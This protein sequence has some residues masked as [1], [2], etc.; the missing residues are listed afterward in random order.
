MNRSCNQ[1]HFTSKHLDS[2]NSKLGEV[3]GRRVN[4]S[5]NDAIAFNEMM[6]ESKGRWSYL[7]YC[8]FQEMNK[9]NINLSEVE[10]DKLSRIVNKRIGDEK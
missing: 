2:M 4:L 1:I 3:L 9:L 10:Y 5:M 6:V 7:T 8:V